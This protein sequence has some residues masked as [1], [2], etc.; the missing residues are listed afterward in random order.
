MSVR[1]TWM[2]II[3]ALVMLVLFVFESDTNGTN[4]EVITKSEHF[5]VS[6]QRRLLP[7]SAEVTMLALKPGQLVRDGGNK[8]PGFYR[9]FTGVWSSWLGYRPVTPKIA[10]SSPVTPAKHIIELE[11]WRSLVAQRTDNAKVGGSNPPF[12]T[13]GV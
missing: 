4:N 11:K 2:K 7:A 5:K 10:G 3:F 12:S 6:W 13:T 9:K 8:R 1:V